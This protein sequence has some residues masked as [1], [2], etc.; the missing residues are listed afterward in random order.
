MLWLLIFACCGLKKNPCIGG[1]QCFLWNS[2]YYCDQLRPEEILGI[3]L[4]GKSCFLEYFLL[5]KL[6]IFSECGKFEHVSSVTIMSGSSG[7]STKGSQFVTAEGKLVF[8]GFII[9]FFFS[10]REVIRVPLSVQVE[11]KIGGGTFNY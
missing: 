5:V 1:A 4:K 6:L 10:E 7:V 2:K 11:Q 3:S 9:I 8:V